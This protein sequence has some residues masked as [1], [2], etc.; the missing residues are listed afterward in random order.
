MVAIGIMAVRER[1]K[2]IVPMRKELGPNTTINFDDARLGP[3]A[4]ARRTWLDLLIM[5][6]P[7]CC[8]LQDDLVLAKGFRKALNAALG[9][10][11]LEADVVAP[12]ANR[13]VLKNIEVAWHRVRD[14][15]WGQAICIR[16]G[17]L[18]EFLKWERE[19]VNPAFPHDDSRV[20]MWLLETNRVSWVMVPSLVDHSGDQNSV[21]GNRT[22]RPRRAT[23]FIQDATAIL[24]PVTNDIGYS[25][26]G[27]MSEYRRKWLR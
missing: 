8:L 23:R 5:G 6:E 9:G 13:K 14:G 11:P 2:Y 20:A 4:N 22:F 3:W 10:L 1:M 18:L 12:Y 15:V 27:S 26:G 24:Y 7:W 25:S 19:H 21:V 16:R 17:S